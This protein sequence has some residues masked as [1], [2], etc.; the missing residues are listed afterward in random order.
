MGYDKTE[1]CRHNDLHDHI[2]IDV[3]L[4]NAS[5]NSLTKALNFLMPG[6]KYA[7]S[8]DLTDVIIY[9]MIKLEYP[10]HILKL[11]GI[12]D[13]WYLYPSQ[14]DLQWLQRVVTQVGNKVKLE[15]GEVT[16]FLRRAQAS[17]A[18]FHLRTETS[19]RMFAIWIT[20]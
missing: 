12:P 3:P 18:I 15:D 7:R 19:S 16:E 6:T 13:R 8:V 1:K 9:L 2:G 14:E 5:V 11:F 10:V 4:D 17:Y 20:P